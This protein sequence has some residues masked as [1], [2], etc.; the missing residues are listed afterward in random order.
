MGISKTSDH[1]QIKIKMPTPSQE[2]PASSKAPNEDLKD[3]DV[4]CT[5]KIEIGS[6]NLDHGYIKDQW[7][8][9]KQDQDAKPL[10]GTSSIL[11]NPQSG[12]K[13]HLCS[14]HLQHQDR[15]PKFG[16]WMYQRPVTICISRSSFGTLVMDL[17]CHQKDKS[18]LTEYGCSLQLDNPC[19]QP[20]FWT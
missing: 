17:Q 14:L 11:Q 18:G 8:Y 19:R 13:G 5:F 20:L 10:S 7:P 3:M 9:Q 4:L 2:P 12:L 1:I 6:Q 15:Q 16:A